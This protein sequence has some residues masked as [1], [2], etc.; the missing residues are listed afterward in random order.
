[1]LIEGA[2]PWSKGSEVDVLRLIPEIANN[3][4]GLRME[5]KPGAVL[6]PQCGRPRFR[7]L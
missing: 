7:Q 4:G 6:A 3:S 5:V 2:H 1:M